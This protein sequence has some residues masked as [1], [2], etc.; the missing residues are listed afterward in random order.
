MDDSSL[1]QHDIELGATLILRFQ[2]SSLIPN[3]P[4]EWKIRKNEE[5]FQAWISKQTTPSLFFDGATKGNPGIAGA[6]GLIINTEGNSIHRFAWGLG[7]SSGIQAESLA[8]FQ[9][10]KLLKELGSKEANVFGDSQ[11]IIKTMV[12]KS[13]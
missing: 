5:D 8:L 12:T 13:S 4:K 2:K 1:F 3:P 7:H 11:V 6:G 9:G 10:I